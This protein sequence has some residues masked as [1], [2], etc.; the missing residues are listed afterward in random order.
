[1]IK[2]IHIGWAAL[3]VPYV[4]FM[5][6]TKLL[7]LI[8]FY[9]GWK[10]LSMGWISSRV[11]WSF[12]YWVR[13]IPQN[14]GYQYEPPKDKHTQPNTQKDINWNIWQ[15]TLPKIVSHGQRI[16][17]Q[18]RES[19]FTVNINQNLSWKEGSS[20]Y[21]WRHHGSGMTWHSSITSNHSQINALI[22]NISGGKLGRIQV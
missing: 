2:I 11:K 19:V 15:N 22:F 10:S 6:D 18:F 9:V 1:M 13:Q 14:L 8:S 5:K 12:A 21:L 20:S 7:A 3:I 4:P 17:V 16:L